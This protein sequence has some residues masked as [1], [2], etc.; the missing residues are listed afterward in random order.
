MTGDC[1]AAGLVSEVIFCSALQW[2]GVMARTCHESSAAG[3]PRNMGLT[4][5][6][7]CIS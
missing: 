4:C 3:I 6:M 1:S 5:K 2:R 7:M